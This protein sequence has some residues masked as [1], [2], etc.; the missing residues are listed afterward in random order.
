M[1]AADSRR[2]ESHSADTRGLWLM[3]ASAAAFAAMAPFTRRWLRAIEPQSIIAAR[4]VV[5][6]ALFFAWGRW[7]GINLLG[8]DRRGLLLRGVIGW[9][10][11]SCYVWSTQHLPSGQ[12]VLLQYSH[13]VF[14]ALLAPLL[15]SERPGPGHWPLVLIGLLGLA[16]AIGVGGELERGASIGLLGAL[17]TGIAYVTVR[18]IS[19]TESPIT[20]VFWFALVM[21]PTSITSCFTPW[22][23]LD[24]LSGWLNGDA[25]AGAA[26]SG[27][28]ALHLLPQD[29][30]E[31]IGY[32][33]VVGVGLLG[34]IT[35]TEG[36]RRAG[37]ARA[38]AVTMVGPLFG[39]VFD[40]LCFSRTPSAT[41]LAGTLL[42]VAALTVLGILK[43][44]AP[45]DAAPT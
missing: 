38:T 26:I 45:A 15:L 4:A 29:G 27:P 5:M 25:G 13:P 11:I 10:S 20:I 30:G 12:A 6:T 33:G 24:M 44:R 14:V 19:A 23:L 31:W 18:R 17:F 34:Q 7:R 8:H 35:L 40:R 43:P 2:T 41:V 28:S 32:L 37:A 39:L 42:V 1:N 16:L 21:L 9:L 22:S 3:V 36:L